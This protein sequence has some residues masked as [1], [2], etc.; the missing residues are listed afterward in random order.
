MRRR[1]ADRVAQV[2]GGV[3]IQG[4]ALEPAAPGTLFV[5]WLRHP[6]GQ[7]EPFEVTVPAPATPGDPGALDLEAAEH[8]RRALFLGAAAP[9]ELGLALLARDAGRQAEAATRL[10]AA[11]PADPS[12][13]MFALGPNGSAGHGRPA[14]GSP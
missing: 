6:D 7:W 1:A 10:A 11:R 4:L 8:Y 2:R 9:A 13:P 5:D 14:T 3:S 12:L